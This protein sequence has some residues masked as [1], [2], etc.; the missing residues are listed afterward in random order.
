MHFAVLIQVSIVASTA[1]RLAVAIGTLL[2]IAPR[3]MVLTGLHV[4]V[5]AGVR[6]IVRNPV[7]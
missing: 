5:V 2:N 6:A 4:A 3:M 1:K 7:N